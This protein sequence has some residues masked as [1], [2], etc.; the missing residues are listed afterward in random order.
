MK[1]ALPAL[2]LAL[3]G[4]ATVAA[5]PAGERTDLTRWTA[6]VLAYQP[7]PIS[8]TTR[9]IGAWEWSRLKP[10]IEQVRSRGTAKVLLKGAAMYL[11]LAVQVTR[12]NRPIYPTS[13]LGVFA[14]D[15]RPLGTHGLDSQI[16]WGRV[17][18]ITALS[19]HDA[20]EQQRELAVTWF[21]TVTAVLSQRLNFADLYAH[22]A[23]AGKYL[24]DDPGL[25][26]DAGCAAE[27]LAS[28][29]LQATIRSRL[30]RSSNGEDSFGGLT[31]PSNSAAFLRD[32]EKD[33]R[34][35]RRALPDHRE[36]QVRLG[37]VLSLLGRYDEALSELQSAGR[38]H[39]DTIVDYFNWLFLGDVLTHTR[40][41]DDAVAAFERARSLYPDA[42]APLLGISHVHSEEGNLTAARAALAP[43]IRT[44]PEAAGGTDPRWHYDRCNGRNSHSVYQRFIERFKQEWP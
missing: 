29:L 33:Y 2:T 35:A 43:L 39:S 10:V 24:A 38:L 34:A 28:P 21:R 15:G 40:R 13:G 9:D 27:T 16:W 5:Q 23:D 6:A 11:D 20:S 1:R 25:L 12:D 8:E 7:G 31:A 19:R 18:V 4:V 32:A 3:F 26:F 41:F 17:L 36:T 14:K 22:L 37:R 30:P 42:G 44:W